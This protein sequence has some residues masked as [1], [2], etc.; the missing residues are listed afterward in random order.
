MKLYFLIS[1]SFLLASN[2]LSKNTDTLTIN[3]IVNSGFQISASISNF[4]K[5]K[6]IENSDQAFL[7]TK[8][9][10]DSY[11]F[12]LLFSLND[13]VFVKTYVLKLDDLNGNY[14]CKKPDVSFKNGFIK[15]ECV[16]M[17]GI[18]FITKLGL[19]NNQLIFIEN[20]QHD[21]NGDV[22]ELAE[23]AK[24]ENDPVMYC[25]AYLGAQYYSDL[26]FRVKESLE[27]AHK[28]ALE[29]YREKKYNEAATI[30]HEM[31]QRCSVSLEMYELMEDSFIQIWS[32]AT[33]F[34]LKA[35][36]NNQ[37]VHLSESLI[38]NHPET[39]GVYLQYG[40]ALYNLNRFEE[41]K[42]I[43]EKY[44]TLMKAKEKNDKIPSRV[45]N[46]IKE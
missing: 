13:S 29:Y 33:L 38:E 35:G 44:I 6:L 24:K 2:C 17:K 19:D 42:L 30:M 40:D 34:Y 1:I 12:N 14:N 32:D 3:E 8:Q 7:A 23:V 39:A 21:L 45:L 36:M 18:L 4:P 27:W 25:E 46:R 15:V 11:I 31:E 10:D 16:W 28:N 22:Y 41:S 9:L 43:Y 20:Y 37:C 26:E 5:E